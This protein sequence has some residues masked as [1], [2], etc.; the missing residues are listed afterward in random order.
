MNSKI[1]TSF[2]LYYKLFDM[3]Y[4]AG[5]IIFLEEKTYASFSN[6]FLYIKKSNCKSKDIYMHLF[7]KLRIISADKC[8]KNNVRVSIV[9]A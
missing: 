5:K 9:F 1:I 6:I 8:K 3:C 4:S 7:N 2:S